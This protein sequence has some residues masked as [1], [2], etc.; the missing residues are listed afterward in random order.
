MNFGQRYL[1]YKNA[2]P[3]LRNKYWGLKSQNSE[4]ETWI[5]GNIINDSFGNNDKIW[6]NIF[7]LLGYFN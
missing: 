1:S 6:E 7:E 4:N 5:L 2:I 3:K